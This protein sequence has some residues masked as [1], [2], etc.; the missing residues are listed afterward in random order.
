MCMWTALR[1]PLLCIS[2]RSPC[3]DMPAA[4]QFALF[5]HSLPLL[6]FQALL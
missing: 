5:S 1:R 4:L 3:E 2:P 6:A